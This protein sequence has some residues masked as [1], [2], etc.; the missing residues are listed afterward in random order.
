M[1]APKVYVKEG[2]KIIEKE[3]PVVEKECW[4]CGNPFMW[5]V[6]QVGVYVD[7]VV[8]FQCCSCGAKVDQWEK[9]FQVGVGERRNK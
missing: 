2:N 4:W 8:W 3:A 5:D 1:E 9:V 6:H 7:E